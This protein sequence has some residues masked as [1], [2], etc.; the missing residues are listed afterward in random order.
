MHCIDNDYW[1]LVPSIS[2]FKLGDSE[3]NHPHQVALDLKCIQVLRA[4]I[5]NEERKLPAD[6]EKQANDHEE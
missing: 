4:M 5:H 1:Q 3:R 6:W 2:A